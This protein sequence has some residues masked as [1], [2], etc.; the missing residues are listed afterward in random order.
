M[1]LKMLATLAILIAIIFSFG[2]GKTALKYYQQA[3]EIRLNPANIDIYETTNNQLKSKK[4]DSEKKRIILFGD[5]RI[6][7]WKN[8]PDIPQIQ[9]INRGIGG[10]TTAQ[11]LLRLE[12]DV[13]SLS[14]DAVVIQIGIND[15]KAIG[16][17]TNRKNG[18]YIAA[19]KNLNEIILRIS[20]QGAHVYL[21]T[22]FPTAE[23]N[24]IRSF[25]WSADIDSAV[26][27]FNQD[28]RKMNSNNLS[29]IDCD[30]IFNID[31][32]MNPNYSLDTLH[33]NKAGYNALSALLTKEL[34]KLIAPNKEG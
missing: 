33:L 13:I 31:G 10:E 28:I 29:V 2:M 34:N 12:K 30:P 21:M 22:V 4:I 3:T 18:I 14:P 23:V 8:L 17:L 11:A 6:S 9:L 20:Q 27:S 32:K 16:V 5:S 7:M 15:L 19:Q 26:N 25:V 1:F 24:F